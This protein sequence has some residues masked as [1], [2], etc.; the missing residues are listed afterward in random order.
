MP[1]ACAA[2]LS[3]SELVLWPSGSPSWFVVSL[4]ELLSSSP[5]LASSQTLLLYLCHLSAT[6]NTSLSETHQPPINM[7]SS[8]KMDH[9]P[10]RLGLRRGHFLPHAPLNLSLLFQFSSDTGA[11]F[12]PPPNRFIPFHNPLPAIL[13]FQISENQNVDFG[14][15][16]FSTALMP[17]FIWQQKRTK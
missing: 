14:F 10:I 3:C 8:E 13:N 1:V 12:P 9:N 2:I 17:N 4:Q 5:L 6:V 7:Q 16:W 15:F 11:A